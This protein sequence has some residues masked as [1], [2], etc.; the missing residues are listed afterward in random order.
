V[1]VR[2]RV[3]NEDTRPVDDVKLWVSLY[4]A[5]GLLTGAVYKDHM[6]PTLKPGESAPFEAFVNQYG[7]NYAKIET[8]YEAGAK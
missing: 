6:M 1:K 8:V 4:D 3:I 2:G 7:A 5:A